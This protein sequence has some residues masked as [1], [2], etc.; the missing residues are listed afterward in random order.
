MHAVVFDIATGELKELDWQASHDL[1]ALSDQYDVYAVN[2]QQVRFLHPSLDAS[3]EIICF[4][5]K[6]WQDNHVMFPFV[7]SSPGLTI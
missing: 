5:S 7:F 4:G 6:L 3:W 2:D 1:K